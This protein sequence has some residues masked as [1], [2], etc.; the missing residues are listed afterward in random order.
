MGICDSSDN[1][2]CSGADAAHC[3]NCFK[4]NETM[5]PCTKG[6]GDEVV[7]N[8]R[9]P[10]PHKVPN[11]R[12]ATHCGRNAAT[13]PACQGEQTRPCTEQCEDGVRHNMFHPCPEAM[14]AMRA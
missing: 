4:A 5:L 14:A 9:H 6:C 13:C 8:C 7:H 1:A 11:Y 2:T 3:P 12:S 10:C